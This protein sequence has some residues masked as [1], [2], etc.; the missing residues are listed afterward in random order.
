M[1]CAICG[2]PVHAGPVSHADCLQLTQQILAEAERRILAIPQPGMTD[3]FRQGVAMA[4]NQIKD[5]QAG[6]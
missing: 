3:D 4:L 2:L 6:R 1:K 5:M